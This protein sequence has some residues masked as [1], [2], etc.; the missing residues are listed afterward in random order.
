MV[1]I[2]FLE[3]MESETPE[4][5]APLR[6]VHKWEKFVLTVHMIIVEKGKFWAASQFLKKFEKPLLDRISKRLIA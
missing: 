5:Q 3:P 2:Y 6:Y 4:V 1:Q